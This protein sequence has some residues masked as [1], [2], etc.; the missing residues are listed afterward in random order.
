MIRKNL[1]VTGLPIEATYSK[2]ERDTVF[3]PLLKKLTQLRKEKNTRL[4]VFLAAPP[5][6]GKTTLAVLLEQLYNETKN[7]SKLQALS[8]DGF[9]HKEAYLTTH[10]TQINGLKTLL[11]QVK[12]KPETFDLEGLKRQIQALHINE[13]VA[14]PIYNRTL[15]DVAEETIEV[16][17]DIILLEGNYLLLDTDGWRDLKDFADFT[18]FLEAPI[19]ILRERIIERKLKGGHVKEEAIAHYERADLPNHHLIM[20]Q[21]QKTDWVLFL[22]EKEEWQI[23]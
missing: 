14:W 23:K 12:G 19:D 10:Y 15:H 1:I 5:G 16:D 3:L 17:A 18:V 4:I 13:A 22:N 9:H 21:S 20:K 2:K 7:P 11:K 6:A 8:M